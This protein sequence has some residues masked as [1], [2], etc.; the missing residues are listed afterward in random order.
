M[1]AATIRTHLLL[2]V[3]ALAVPLVA[4]VGFEIYA[5]NQLVV[6]Q[7]KGTLRTL[8]HTM[9]SNTGGKIASA[10]KTLEQLALR[11]LVRKLDPQACDGILHDLIALHAD[12][13]NVATTNMDGDVVCS[14]LQI[15]RDKRLNFA[16]VPAFQYFQKMQR[17]DVGQPFMGP[18]AKK[19]VSILST[20]IWNENHEMIGG[21]HIP[22][23]INSYDPKIPAQFL[24]EGSRYGFM[25]DDGIMVWR[26]LD[27]E[28]VIGTRPD[29]DAAREVVRVRD[30]EFESIAVDGVRRYFSVV[31]MPEVGWIAF[32]GV[33]ASVVY[34]KANQRALTMAV[35]AGLSIT[36][37]GILALAIARRIAE[38]IAAL[39]TV[40]RKVHAGDHGARAAIV[41][42]DEVQAVAAAFNEMTD[43]L[44]ATAQSLQAE[45][46]ERHEMES[47]VRQ[48][49][50]HDPLTGLPNRHLLTDRMHQAMAA[51]A[52]SGSHCAV[53]FLDLDHFK[54]LNDTHGHEVGDLL[55]KEVAERLRR[56]VRQLD[57]VARFG[58]DEFVVML[59]ELNADQ[60]QSVALARSIAEK[61]R[62]LLSAPYL[63]T[64]T[65]AA[66][67]DQLVEY[68]CSASI[69][70]VLFLAQRT[71]QT[72]ILKWA[73]SA[74]YQ[75]KKL[76]GNTVYF[77]RSAN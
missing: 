10:R 34:E 4:F 18:I 75:A 50:F 40:A 73:D 27:P 21:V 62:A 70:V 53:M 24:P 61:I 6:T 47:Q 71:S 76:G 35:I 14:G 59:G 43:S 26:N 7:T 22:M 49:A 52:R 55:L 56:C 60:E 39:A 16:K 15:P 69:G 3:L 5:Q 13:A 51:S 64:I 41:G 11:P 46:A 74:M 54:P 8:A 68:R 20:P 57:T 33:P 77:D 1:M 48:M 31:P 38:P 23:D 25:R 2:L 63:L 37:Q 42:P 72:D 45:I 58:G 28:G 17:F 67:A 30:G 32:V 44:H 36:L 9:A 66:H 19:W 12:Y 65:Q 29:A